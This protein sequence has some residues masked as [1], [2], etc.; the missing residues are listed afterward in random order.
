M[1]SEIRPGNHGK[2][3]AFGLDFS[4]HGNAV[5]N[6][7]DSLNDSIILPEATFFSLLNQHIEILPKNYTNLEMARQDK[8]KSDR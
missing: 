4:T 8:E 1:S 6:M 2:I 3:S 5:E 7:F